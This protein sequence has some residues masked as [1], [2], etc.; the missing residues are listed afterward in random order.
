M[1]VNLRY[2]D[3]FSDD[4]K[5]DELR[6]LLITFSDSI[7]L[8]ADKLFSHYRNLRMFQAFHKVY[9]EFRAGEEVS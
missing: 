7:R 6:I 3:K 1:K 2:V 4:C 8:F 9:Y 5:S